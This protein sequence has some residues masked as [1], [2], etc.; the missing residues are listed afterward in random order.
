MKNQQ[1]TEFWH[2][3]VL[4]IIS[5]GLAIPILF[6][7][8]RIF[9]DHSHDAILGWAIAVL[10]LVF[11]FLAVSCL[12]WEII[13]LYKR[14][15]SPSASEALPFTVFLVGLIAVVLATGLVVRV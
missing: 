6:A 9:N 1:L 4:G 2:V 15:L 8:Q 14:K 11:L 10:A 5:C 3:L 12:G 7:C 13:L